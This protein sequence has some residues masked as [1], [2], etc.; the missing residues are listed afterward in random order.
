M[1]RIVVDAN[2]FIAASISDG[3]TRKILFES[4]FAILVPEHVF[5]ELEKHRE[6]IKTKTGCD[7]QYFDVLITRILGRIKPISFVE[8][9]DCMSYAKQICPDTKDVLYFALAL[10]LNCPVWSNETKLKNQKFIK[11]Y[12]TQELLG[13]LK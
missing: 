11:V 4:N 1:R 8:F 2:V 10:K 6:E 12:S 5:Y 13:M 9:Y 3:L 7:D